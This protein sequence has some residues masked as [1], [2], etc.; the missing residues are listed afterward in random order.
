[1]PHTPVTKDQHVTF[2]DVLG[3]IRVCF[4]TVLALQY[5]G[6]TA[7]L[8]ACGSNLRKATLTVPISW[9]FLTVFRDCFDDHA[10]GKHLVPIKYSNPRIIGFRI[11]DMDCGCNLVPYVRDC[12]ESRKWQL[13]HLNTM[14]YDQGDGPDMMHPE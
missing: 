11:M 3:T 8:L 12:I 4:S 13:L 14:A 6:S 7:S 9:T 5:A 1:M 2:A 10:V